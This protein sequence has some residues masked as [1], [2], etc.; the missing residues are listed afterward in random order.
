MSS[1]YNARK[2]FLTPLNFKGL[3]LRRII[4]FKHDVSST[5]WN[6]HV[7]KGKMLPNQVIARWRRIVATVRT[8]TEGDCQVL[9][10]QAM[11]RIGICCRIWRMPKT[12]ERQGK[13]ES[14]FL[15]Y[16]SL[17]QLRITFRVFTALINKNICSAPN[18]PEPS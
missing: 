14:C 5:E 12:G 10:W 15:S 7:A 18:S 16:I 11:E 4:C 17:L 1:I 8:H 2:Y 13:G 3:F 6:N 9:R